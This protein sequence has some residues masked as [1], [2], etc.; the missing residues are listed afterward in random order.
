MSTLK[1]SW[2]LKEL[3]INANLIT[4]L[5]IEVE[6]YIQRNEK[7]CAGKAQSLSNIFYRNNLQTILESKEQNKTFLELKAINDKYV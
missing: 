4:E 2:E 3:L 7:T 6:K 1:S 5:R